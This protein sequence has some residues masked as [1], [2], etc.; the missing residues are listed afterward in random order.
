MKKIPLYI[1]IASS[2]LSLNS[3]ADSEPQQHEQELVPIPNQSQPPVQ[4]KKPEIHSLSAFT[5][6][7]TK[8]KVRMRLQPTLDSLI[9]REMTA[10]DMVIVVGE[11]DDFYAIQPPEEI[12]GYV[13]RTYILDGV[14]EGNHVNVRLEPDLNSPVVAQLNSGDRINGSI[15]PRDKKWFEISLP[16]ATHF[17]IAKEYVEKI[18]DA[19]YMAK[20]NKRHAE[21]QQLLSDASKH[22]QQE[23]Q[24]PFS[25]INLDPITRDLTKVVNQ[26]SDFTEESAKAKE[27]LATIQTAYLSKKVAYMES[28][29]RIAALEEHKPSA[30]AAQN[31]SINSKMAA[32]LPEEQK[33]YEEWTGKHEHISLEEFY[34]RQNKEGVDLKGIVEA[35]NKPFKNKPGDYLLVNSATHLPVAYL[36]S[37][38]VNL[39]EKLGQEVAIKGAQRDNRHFAYPAYYVLTI[40]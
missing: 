28:A 23:L 12:K 25:Q 27:L 13:F 11:N 10:N 36:Y 34:Q 22:S 35:Y 5:G 8:S 29:P 15:S 3:Y 33:F 32:W 17:Y 39:Q 6:K 16:A 37:T 14:V 38:H 4:A 9:L 40:E 24:K 21:V 20:W 31:P 19:G 7:I 26:F 1:L 18:G 30:Q 2:F